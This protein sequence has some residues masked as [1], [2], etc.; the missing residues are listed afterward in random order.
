MAK[1]GDVCTFR[2][3][4]LAGQVARSSGQVGGMQKA[5]SVKNNLN[6]PE[7]PSLLIIITCIMFTGI[8]GNKIIFICGASTKVHQIGKKS[9]THDQPA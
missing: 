5:K 6:L 9:T 2:F 8:L 3:P 7:L 4:Y 1:L